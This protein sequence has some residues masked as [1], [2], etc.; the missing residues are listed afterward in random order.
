MPE[1]LVTSPSVTF[2]CGSGPL[3]LIQQQVLTSPCQCLLGWGEL[4]YSCC[5][6]PTAHMS[7]LPRR[8]P[9]LRLWVPTCVHIHRQPV[10]TRDWGWKGIIKK[11]RDV[12]D[13]TPRLLPGQ[14]W[15]LGEQRS[16]R[17]S[18][19]SHCCPNRAVHCNCSPNHRSTDRGHV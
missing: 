16:C 19:G 18:A 1:D 6:S 17:G 10:C 14:C 4:G 7:L 5:P 13:V 15:Y 3:V 9:S 11:T 12:G 2:C 8:K